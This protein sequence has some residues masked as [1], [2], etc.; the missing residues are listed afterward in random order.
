M[1]SNFDA[2]NS[3]FENQRQRQLQG[4]MQRRELN[5][6]SL[7]EAER[8]KL[9]REKLDQ[10]MKQ[11]ASRM[12]L[13]Y[14]SLA[15][16]G[17]LSRE[18]LAAQM[19]QAASERAY[20]GTEAENARAF[21]RELSSS[22]KADRLAAEERADKR[23]LSAK[24]L[25]TKRYQD[26]Q[27]ARKDEMDF[28][29]QQARSAEIRGMASS[30]YESMKAEYQRAQ[31]TGDY[32]YP[33]PSM[34]RA[35]AMAKAQY[36]SLYPTSP[37]SVSAGVPSV[38]SPSVGSMIQDE[39][40]KVYPSSQPTE[41]DIAAF[42]SSIGSSGVT[43]AVPSYSPPAPIG[44][45]TGNEP[46]ATPIPPAPT[47]SG[48]YSTPEISNLM[49]SAQK[50]FESGLVDEDT[51]KDIEA[52]AGT[53]TRGT[54]YRDSVNALRQ[55][56]QGG[57]MASRE[58]KKARIESYTSK[59]DSYK[60]NQKQDM[61]LRE[62]KEYSKL[63]SDADEAIMKYKAGEIKPEE[64]KKAIDA[65]ESYGFKKQDVANTEARYQEILNGSR[66]TDADR[67]NPILM[68]MVANDA[69]NLDS[70]Q[71][72]LS[73]AAIQSMEGYSGGDFSLLQQWYPEFKKEKWAYLGLSNLFGGESLGDTAKGISI[74]ENVIRPLKE[75]DYS[76]FPEL[77]KMD[78]TAREA[79]AAKILADAESRMF[80]YFGIKRNQPTT[81]TTSDK[82]N[83]TSKSTIPS[84]S[85]Q[86]KE[87]EEALDRQDARFYKNDQP[88]TGLLDKTQ[89]SV[90]EIKN[91]LD[92]K[93]QA[94]EEVGRYPEP[95]IG[96]V[97]IGNE[98][99]LPKTYDDYNNSD[100]A[101][102]DRLMNESV[103]QPV[104]TPEEQQQ[105]KL[106]NV[107]SSAIGSAANA[108]RSGKAAVEGAV[109][110]AA[111]SMPSAADV[112]EALNM[113]IEVP[114]FNLE[115]PNIDFSG[116]MPE[117]VQ[118]FKDTI[119]YYKAQRPL[120]K[121]P[122]QEDIVS[123]PEP[124]QRE[125]RKQPNQED[126]VS[127]PGYKPQRG[128]YYNPGELDAMLAQELM[129]DKIRQF[130]ERDKVERARNKSSAP[131]SKIIDTIISQFPTLDFSGLPPVMRDYYNRIVDE[132]MSMNGENLPSSSPYMI[133]QKE[134]EKQI[135]EPRYYEYPPEFQSPDSRIPVERNRS[136]D[137][138]IPYERQGYSPMPYSPDMKQ[139][140]E[141][142]GP[143]K[144][145]PVE[146]G[147]RQEMNKLELMKEAY[148]RM[149]SGREKDMLAIDIRN[150]DS[151][152]KQEQIKE[153]V[154]SMPNESLYTP[155]GYPSSPEVKEAQRE[156]ELRLINK[157]RNM[158][159]DQLK[160]ARWNATEQEKAFIN[161]ELKR[162]ERMKQ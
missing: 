105:D 149:P 76:D 106:V 144:V 32:S 83:D 98:E 113:G 86:V 137:E 67:K 138:M 135:R 16:Q 38:S 81:T 25:E 51:F 156:L 101:E 91:T 23:R 94:E 141:R 158:D 95:T 142:I 20:R 1:P 134:Q 160:E 15:Q 64:V 46:A 22:E 161:I 39:V 24:E 123:Y 7:T 119:E 50:L 153:S 2:F 40:Q 121:Q 124:K 34:D 84:Y 130:R 104:K 129:I 10:D 162:R 109:E 4:A 14:A 72:I 154:R 66:I 54:G 79:Y 122:N 112:V 57:S 139:P 92:S 100:Q 60:Q 62:D 88:T 29:R 13:D 159:E 3:S 69:T 110:S 58:N 35:L 37:S 89:K 17:A 157:Y 97:K 12:G 117:D 19:E 18:G 73:D 146:S 136:I 102:Y 21:Q 9:E 31:E 93:K 28:R 114:D 45:A 131:E 127:Y 48:N 77:A 87:A 71:S 55:L 36:D 128:P 143:A 85:D 90:D 53:I 75:R 52:F 152:I 70:Y 147:V 155:K 118:K 42:N 33:A 126:I 74:F 8:R 63:I 68:D 47:T 80:D 132:Y 56:I 61:Q 103:N 99:Y 5:L 108:Y 27:Q 78:K 96:S 150:Q 116:L 115:L 65:V 151:K 82:G 44:P 140:I 111:E 59:M 145:K 49:N 26:E 6:R 41:A 107:A 11:F 148:R 125:L 43:S 30:I 120:R 133:D